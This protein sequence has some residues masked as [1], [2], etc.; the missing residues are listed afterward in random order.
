LIFEALAASTKSCLRV[1]PADAFKASSEREKELSF[2]DLLHRLRLFCFL[3]V[4]IIL[5]AS[6]GYFS[7]FSFNPF[8]VDI[9]LA[10]LVLLLLG[11]LTL[12][13]LGY[14]MRD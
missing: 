1:R 6:L 14:L 9:I 2:E 3:L 11:M 13:L 8:I 7:V 12:L 5:I 4:G 10:V